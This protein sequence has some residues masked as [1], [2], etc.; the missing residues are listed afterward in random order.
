[1]SIKDPYIEPGDTMGMIAPSMVTSPMRNKQQQQPA[2]GSSS[3][4]TAGKFLLDPLNQQLPLGILSSSTPS[5][6]H[7]NPKNDEEND[8]LELS[9]DPSVVDREYTFDVE[10]DHSHT[11][12]VE[13]TILQSH[14]IE[15][16]VPESKQ[17]LS[18]AEMNVAQITSSSSSSATSLAN[19]GGVL[20]GIPDSALLRNHQGHERKKSTADVLSDDDGLE[21]ET[22][23]TTALSTIVRRESSPQPEP[24]TVVGDDN[25]KL[26]IETVIEIKTPDEQVQPL[27]ESAE[28]LATAFSKLPATVNEEAGDCEVNTNPVVT[29]LQTEPKMKVFKIQSPNRNHQDGNG[30]II[31]KSTLESDLPTKNSWIL[32]DY[33]Q[34]FGY[35]KNFH[36]E[37]NLAKS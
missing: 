36:S 11:S 26:G 21:Y 5:S 20:F 1:M 10:S 2:F 33:E 30:P 35:D 17:S 28:I 25:E 9:F 29:E 18:A 4:I 31:E 27:P 13:R 24:P 8:L 16:K 22:A 23:S 19:A 7:G 6:A 14:I 32:Q 37:I 3:T 12:E 15:V 34:L